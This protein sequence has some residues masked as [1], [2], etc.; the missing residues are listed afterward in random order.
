MPF[1]FIAERTDKT[2]SLI[3]DVLT[4]TRLRPTAQGRMR[5]V[6]LNYEK[7]P[8]REE[9]SSMGP[10]IAHSIAII[11]HPHQLFELVRDGG[12]LVRDER[13]PLWQRFSGQTH[14]GIHGQ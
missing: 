11:A 13:G 2:W 10:T 7:A 12:I 6:T 14:A 3:A 1:E 8:T 5:Q 4:E 9:F